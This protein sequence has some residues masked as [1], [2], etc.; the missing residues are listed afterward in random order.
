MVNFEATCISDRRDTLTVEVSAGDVASFFIERDG[1][2]S[3]DKVVNLERSDVRRLVTSLI[4][5]GY[6]PATSTPADGWEEADRANE[7]DREEDQDA[8]ISALESGA[9]DVGALLRSMQTDIDD[10]ASRLNASAQ[11]MFGN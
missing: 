3:V 8:R 2:F 1:L 11:A 10:L 5:A 4:A 9:L 6:G 7:P